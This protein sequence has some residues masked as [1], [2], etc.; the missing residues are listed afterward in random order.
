M[1]THAPDV[2]ALLDAAGVTPRGITA[3]SRRVAPGDVFA[4]WPGAANDGRRYIDDALSRGA[5]A[6]LYESGDGFSLSDMGRPTV[7]VEGLRSL[8]GFIADEIYGRPSETLWLTGVT[9]TN[10]KTTISQWLA[11]ALD[12]LGSRC[13][14]IGTLGSGFP[15]ALV[16]G[17]N[18]TPDALE[19]H[20]LLAGFAAD[21][22]RAVAMEVS[23]IGLDQERVNGARFDIAVF[24]N[25]TRDHLDYHGSMQAYAE[26]KTRLFDL[27]GLA[28][29]I[30]NL[31]DDFGLELAKRQAAIGMRVIGYTVKER[32]G[33]VLPGVEALSGNY[34]RPSLTGQ[35]F[36]LAWEGY[37]A[38][39]DVRL[40]GAFNISNLLAVVGA[41]LAHGLE[42]DD[43]LLAVKTLTPPPGR[44][45]LLGSAGDPLVI[46]D[47][48]HTPD[49]LIKVLEAAR[50][51]ARARDGQLICVFGCGGE[52]DPGKRP[53]MG[54]AASWLADRVIVTSDNPRGEDPRKIIE[55]I[56]VGAG[57]VAKAVTERAEAIRHAIGTSSVNDVIVIAGKGH[58]PYQEICGE[59]RPFSDIEQAGLALAAREGRMKA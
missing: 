52:R 56:I 7:A 46:V 25:L 41:L 37:R 11:R 45:Q 30:I 15:D 57:P 32:T 10:G 44:M 23:S 33:A 51:I 18:T 27:P 55:A 54:E 53:Q 2:F 34:L 20:R 50:E 31:D 49:A 4:A 1:V 16:A 59:R 17:L 24:S 42:L 38:L 13:G 19:L 43:A 8:A 48:A 47:Y 12:A 58:E 6:V 40:A 5:A 36:D 39:L 21:G 3:D 35:A 22:A 28:A 29:A 26:A 14:V 9:G